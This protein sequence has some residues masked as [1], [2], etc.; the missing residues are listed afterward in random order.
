MHKVT[1]HN[2]GNADCIRIDLENGRQALFD[3][4]HMGNPDD[5]DD[6]RCNLPK[7]LRDEL[8]NRDHYDIVA[9]THLDRDHYARATEFFFFEHIKKYQGLV[10]GKSRIKIVVMWVPA[11]VI[12]E[13]LPRDADAEAKAIQKEARERFKAKKGI[14][15]FS[16]PDRL[17][18]WCEDNDVDLDERRALITDA[19]QLAPEFTLASDGVEFFVHSPFAVRQDANTVEDRNCDALVMHATFE[20]EDH[21]TRIFLASDADST[22]LTDIV[23]VTEAKKNEERLRWDLF[24]LPHHCSHHSLSSEKRSGDKSKPEPMVSRLFEQYA[25][26]GAIVVSTSAPIPLKGSDEDKKGANPP[27]RQ[28]ANYYRED[29]VDDDGDFKV[30]MAH[31]TEDSPE[32]L[33]I[34]IGR[35]GTTIRK[36]VHAA[37]LYAV[38]SRPPRAG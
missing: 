24:K 32:P 25:Q 35:L 15:V 4:A 23:N 6:L 30:T 38:L 18:Q 7:V 8:G 16:R 11:A 31:P 20:V 3:Y 34:E 13:K 26:A 2:L 29:V 17:K 36:V 14:R 9:F 21:R 27:H 22:V 5:E 33:L 19:G 12:T 37:G 28:A 1:F 10:D